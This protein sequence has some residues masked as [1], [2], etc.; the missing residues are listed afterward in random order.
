MPVR[1]ARKLC[2]AKCQDGHACLQPAMPNGR[3]KTHRGKAPVGRANT[4][5]KHGRYSKHLPTRLAAQYEQARDDPELH[6]VR[7]EIGVVE[8]RVRELLARIEGGDLGTLWPTLHKQ[9]QAYQAARRTGDT[10]TMSK[11][12]AAMEPLIAQGAQD[13]TLWTTI[14]TELDRLA[15]LRQTEHRRLVDMQQMITAERANLLM[16][17]MV[18]IIAG[19]LKKHIPDETQVRRIYGDI[20]RGLDAQFAT[21]LDRRSPGGGAVRA[22]SVAG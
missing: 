17:A 7:D 10:P 22:R 18:S 6:S 21:T 14:G 3:C 1:G 13:Y 16:G 4:A 12:L 11:A 15:R 19:V 2:G 8:A 20:G 5:Y 9:L